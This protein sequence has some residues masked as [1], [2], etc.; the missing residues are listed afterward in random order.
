ML[1]WL[2]VDKQINIFIKMLLDSIYC[3]RKAQ[4]YSKY[5]PERYVSAHVAQGG[6]SVE[7]KMKGRITTHLKFTQKKNKNWF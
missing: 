7:E 4:K 1:V 3:H 2:F 6:G 5:N